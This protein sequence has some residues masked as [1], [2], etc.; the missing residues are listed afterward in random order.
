MLTSSQRPSSEVASASSEFD[1]RA[2][3]EPASIATNRF[4]LLCFLVENLMQWDSS[5]QRLQLLFWMPIP[6]PDLYRIQL[7]KNLATSDPAGNPVKFSPEELQL[8]I[9]ARLD[10]YRAFAAIAKSDHKTGMEILQLLKLRFPG[11]S[12]ILFALGKTWEKQKNWKTALTCYQEAQKQSQL[13]TGIA[14]KLGHH[15]KHSTKVQGNHLIDTLVR[16]NQRNIG[17]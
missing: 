10:L 12:Y 8:V 13:I 11:A 6:E 2:L 15:L 3:R 4:L 1:F 16:V 7:A 14:D 9:P 5:N 17:L